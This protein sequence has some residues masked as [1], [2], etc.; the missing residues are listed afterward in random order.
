MRYVVHYYDA[1]LIY[2]FTH[3]CKFIRYSIHEES[4]LRTN[5]AIYLYLI[6]EKLYI[7]C[8]I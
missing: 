6:L 5:I 2:D 4:S 3:A 7:K 8:S 1:F